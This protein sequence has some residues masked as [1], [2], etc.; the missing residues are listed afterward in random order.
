LSNPI[1]AVKGLSH[2]YASGS[3]QKQALQDITLEIEQGSCVA[4]IGFNGSGKSTLVQHFNG[5]L[6]PTRGE[7]IVDGINVGMKGADLRL[8][9]QR[10][11]ILFQFPE[12]QLFAPTVF[13]DVAFGPQRMKLS[14]R[15]V[16]TRVQDALEAVGLP[17]QEYGW[18]SPFDLSGG[19]RRRIALAGVLAMSPK[20]LILDEPSV[21]LDGETR[22]EFYHYLKQ[23]QQERGVTIVLV[24]HDMS[25]VAAMADWIFVLH[26][27]RLMMQGTPRDVF[28]HAQQLREWHLAV[29][30]LNEFLARLREHGMTIPDDVFTLDEAVAFLREH[31]HARAHTQKQLPT[32]VPEAEADH[33]VPVQD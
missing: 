25:E 29:P 18:R 24:S 21:G 7:V 8:L 30:P 14:R 9:R 10:V 15:E 23:V 13:A 31:F 20:V 28:N 12:A 33:S 32:Q 27:G 2:T 17:Q 1:I 16:R 11:G 5:L 6:R 26:Q 4:I 19:Q 22:A 3:L